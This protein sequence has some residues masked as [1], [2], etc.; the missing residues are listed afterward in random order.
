M[1][2]IAPS[3]NMDLTTAA[4]DHP[5]QMSCIDESP[6]DIDD[7]LLGDVAPEELQL[8]PP[9]IADTQPPT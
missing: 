6:Q 8:S 1:H 7:T 4:E 5:T 3:L 9:L 2:P